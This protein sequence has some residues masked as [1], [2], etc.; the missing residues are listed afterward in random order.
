MSTEAVMHDTTIE[1]RERKRALE[2]LIIDESASL[3]RMARR[4]MGD[5]EEAR[6][7]LQ[8]TFLKAHVSIEG[9]RAESS[10]K[11]WVVSILINQGLK[12]LRRRKLS[13]RVARLFGKG[14]EIVPGGPA[15]W[16]AHIDNPEQIASLRERAASL[17][18]AMNVLS[19]RQH[20]VFVLRYLEQRSIDEIA[21]L[22]NIASGTVK[23]HLVRALGRIRD[24]ESS[25]QEA[26]DE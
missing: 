11:T 17:Q 1:F 4:L 9:F 3:F 14:P 2:A 20:T 21:R 13:R 18:A 26:G 16:G 15:E 24:H 22:M 6:D 12:K 23:T 19:P 7:L 8:D 10:L 25:G 5:D